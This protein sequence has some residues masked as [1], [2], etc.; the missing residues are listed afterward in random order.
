MRKR[1]IGLFTKLI[2][3]LAL[4]TGGLVPV[5]SAMAHAPGAMSMMTDM[6]HHQMSG[7]EMPGKDMPCCDHRCW[8]V[9][10]A[11]A[12]SLPPLSADLVTRVGPIS[13]IIFDCAMG[14]G[15]TFPPSIRPPISG[16]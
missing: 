16:A 13:G 8:C 1:L 6:P 11:C 7:Q 15:I 9:A 4:L 14:A 5:S 12:G 3:V 2:L 10:G